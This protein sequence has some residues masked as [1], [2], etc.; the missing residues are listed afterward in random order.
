MDVKTLQGTDAI[1][2]QQRPKQE[3]KN[4]HM[5]YTFQPMVGGI[6]KTVYKFGM[7]GMEEIMQKLCNV[8]PEGYGIRVDVKIFPLEQDSHIKAMLGKN[9]PKVEGTKFNANQKVGD[10][11][12]E[13]CA[14][15]TENKV[16]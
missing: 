1:P 3:N 5:K 10:K 7:G 13:M 4:V 16:Q 12:A 2:V 8:I 11:M 15:N 9:V 14:E 6:R